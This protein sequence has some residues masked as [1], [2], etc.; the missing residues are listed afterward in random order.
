MSRLGDRFGPAAGQRSGHSQRPMM[1]RPVDEAG[2]PR[3]EPQPDQHRWQRVDRGGLAEGRQWD[4]PRRARP[5][6]RRWIGPLVLLAIA[7]SSFALVLDGLTSIS[8]P[9]EAQPAIGSAPL[10]GVT[11]GDGR[12][13]GSGATPSPA[14]I[15]GPTPS[16][17]ATGRPV[18]R[19]TLGTPGT[20]SSASPGPSPSVSPEGA[21]PTA[22]PSST[23]VPGAAPAAAE[24]FDTANPPVIDITFPF[25]ADVRYR[26]RDNWL[27]A[28]HGPPEEYNHLRTARRG[29][30]VRAHDGID[31]YVRRGTPV[32]APFAG[33]VIDPAERWQ[34]WHAER[35]GATVAIASEEASSAGY[36]ALLTHLEVAFAEVGDVVRRG[37]VV[38]LA[39]NSGNAED[40]RAHLH[41]ELRA[42][43]ALEWRE[44]DQV[45]LVDAFNPYPSLRAADPRAD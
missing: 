4:R 33:Q 22:T 41:L 42:P 6:I 35:Y 14:V 28:R 34:P 31:I 11:A 15:D 21:S 2:L 18:A 38:G 32:L 44:G 29:K 1:A 40:S 17:L 10:A 19:A 26:Y 12:G 30:P 36:V 23:R 39:G 3:A 20:G 27:H 5:S 43:F 16:A 13:A 45:R 9:T 24:E 7:G 25:K 8:Q 37:E